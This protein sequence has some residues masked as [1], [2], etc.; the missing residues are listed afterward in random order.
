MQMASTGFIQLTR[1]L[2]S[3]YCTPFDKRRTETINYRFKNSRRV[4][5]KTQKLSKLYHSMRLDPAKTPEALS[6]LLML[7][8]LLA[9]H[10]HQEPASWG[11]LLRAKK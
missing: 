9:R 11:P 6:A 2:L 10:Q 5:S 4:Q 7:A 8:C 1:R 3:L